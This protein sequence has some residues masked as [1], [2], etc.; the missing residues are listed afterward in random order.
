MF[1][2]FERPPKKGVSAGVITNTVSAIDHSKMV[3]ADSSNLFIPRF[4][5][6]AVDELVNTGNC[7]LAPSNYTFANTQIVFNKSWAVTN[8]E[9]AQATSQLVLLFP[10]IRFDKPD[11]GD[12]SGIDIYND[13]CGLVKENATS[14]TFSGDIVTDTSSNCES[15]GVNVTYPPPD[16]SGTFF[17]APT[18]VY[19][20][21]TITDVQLNWS[22]NHDDINSQVL[23]GQ[24]I[25]PQ[26]AIGDRLLNISGL[27]L[28]DDSTWNL[29]AIHDYGQVDLSDKLDFCNDVKVFRASNDT[30]T[31]TDIQALPDSLSCNQMG[32]Y[33][34]GDTVS[35]PYWFIVYPKNYTS[36]SKIIDTGNLFNVP[37]IIQSG[38]TNVTN[39]EGFI[40]EYE[41]V[42]L[43]NET[44]N[45]INLRVS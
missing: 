26:P 13:S 5:V 31:G 30:V 15:D 22:Y 27:S 1:G 41:V 17:V 38:T 14:I 28:T 3:F 39:S 25:P 29:D 34:T 36:V 24:G 9:W 18:L 21:R 16:F 43:L 42:R 12:G 23:S 2:F 40:E 20:G 33:S 35:D 45:N 32:D 4:Y 8:P 10:D 37:F 19:R 44:F 7:N 11:G 6:S